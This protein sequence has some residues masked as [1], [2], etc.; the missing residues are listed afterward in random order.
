MQIIC[1]DE[2]ILNCVQ[3]H[4][5]VCVCSTVLQVLKVLLTAVASAKFRGIR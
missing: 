2:L 5:L 1:V 4:D 3:Y